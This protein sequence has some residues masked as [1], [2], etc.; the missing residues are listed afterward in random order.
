MLRVHLSGRGVYLRFSLVLVEHSHRW[1]RTFSRGIPRILKPLRL[2]ISRELSVRKV[3]TLNKQVLLISVLAPT[4][5]KLKMVILLFGIA[6][7]RQSI[8]HLKQVLKL[9][10]RDALGPFLP[11][12]FLNFVL[13][14]LLQ[15]FVLQ[16]LHLSLFVVQELLELFKILHEYFSS[17]QSPLLNH[18]FGLWEE[19][20]QI[21]EDVF[22]HTQERGSVLF[23]SLL[24][25]VLFAAD[26][27]HECRPKIVHKLVLAE[28]RVLRQLYEGGYSLLVIKDGGPFRD[29][30]H[31]CEFLAMRHDGLSWLVDSAIHAHDQLMLEAHICIQE[32]RVEV[33]L[34]RLE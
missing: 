5:I 11:D 6:V 19:L 8:L 15:P 18:N 22:F 28:E 12:L 31:L 29:E 4:H 9:L 32:E 2:I 24:H 13:L 23:G 21:L 26:L 1:L 16:K 10:V 7:L 20:E 27:Y 34:E 33:V 17:F 25:V 14:L 3:I 30:I